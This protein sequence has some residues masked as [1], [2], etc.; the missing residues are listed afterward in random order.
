MTKEL[1][2]YAEKFAIQKTF[3]VYLHPQNK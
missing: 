1:K 2:K 3:K